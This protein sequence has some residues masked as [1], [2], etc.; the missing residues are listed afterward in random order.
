MNDESIMPP[1][2][3]LTP[4]LALVSFHGRRGA[5]LGLGCA[6]QDRKRSG[7]KNQKPR[8]ISR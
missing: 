6:T 2:V 8:Y 5:T 1:R 3:V 7:T 4:D